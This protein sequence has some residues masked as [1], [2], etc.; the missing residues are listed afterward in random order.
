MPAKLQGGLIT[1]MTVAT[2]FGATDRAAASQMS[3]PKA[4]I[5]TRS[6]MRRYQQ[7]GRAIR[8]SQG[9]CPRPPA[10]VEIVVVPSDLN[11]VKR[12]RCQ[13]AA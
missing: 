1:R 8:K 10:A 13:E 2:G 11:L 3:S 9:G 4:D 12:T 7:K 5:T 6:P